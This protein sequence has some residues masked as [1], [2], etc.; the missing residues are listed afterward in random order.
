[1]TDSFLPLI[2]DEAIVPCTLNGDICYTRRSI[3]I[4]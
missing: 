4:A 3:P 2:F 1:M